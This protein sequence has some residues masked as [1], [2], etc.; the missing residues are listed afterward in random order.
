MLTNYTTMTNLIKYLFVAIVL[1]AI[2]SCSKQSGITIG[3]LMPDGEG[4][5]WPI[6]QSYVEKAAADKG[7]KVLSKFVLNDENL[8][9]KQAIEL[10]EMGI[11][12][13][14]IVSVNANTAAAMVREAQKYNVPVIGY[15]RLIKNSDLDYFVS[16]EGAQIGNLMVEHALKVVPKGNYVLLYG[17]A[18]DNNAIYIKDAQEAMLQPYVD[19]GDINIV[20]KG[21]VDNWRADNAYHMM[22]RVL[23]FTDQ[24]IDAVITGYDGLAMGAL[25]ALK[26]HPEQKVKVLTGQ[27][28]ELDAIKALITDEMSLTVYKSIRE[29]ATASVDLAVKLASGQRIDNVNS[30]VNNG[31]KDVPALLLQPVAVQKENIRATVIA[32]EYYSEEEVYGSLE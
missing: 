24:Q 21:F 14:I 19:K 18:G 3:F 1:V 30:T 23:S 29:I 27:D 32:D 7:A 10:L 5:R 6:D 11:D 12:V 16:F 4:S 31:R 26:E 13:L 28:A 15:D 22:S 20:Y 8:Q 25:K 17:D 2:S 9:Q